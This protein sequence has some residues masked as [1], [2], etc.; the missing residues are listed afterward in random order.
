[1]LSECFGIKLRLR[2]GDGL[3]TLQ[4]KKLISPNRFLE[5]IRLCF[6]KFFC[7][8]LGRMENNK[9]IDEPFYLFLTFI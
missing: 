5:F 3:I 7:R 4:V 1:M 2:N 6:F 8:R 9:M